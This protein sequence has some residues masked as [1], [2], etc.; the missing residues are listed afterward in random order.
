MTPTFMRTNLA[1]EP[2]PSSAI[3]PMTNPP[4]CGGNTWATLSSSLGAA[5]TGSSGKS[6]LSR[7]WSRI[8]ARRAARSIPRSIASSP[9]S[10]FR[11]KPSPSS[12]AFGNRTPMTRTSENGSGERMTMAVMPTPRTFSWTV[13]PNSTRVTSSPPTL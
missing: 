5:L 8:P 10:P 9:P 1:S 7:M 2:Q 13:P 4:G 6:I 12:M 11:V 3:G